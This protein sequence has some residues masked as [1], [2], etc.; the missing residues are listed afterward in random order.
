MSACLEMVDLNDPLAISREELDCFTRIQSDFK[1]SNP[2]K[3]TYGN[4]CIQ[5]F[6]TDMNKNPR[7]FFKT[8]IDLATEKIDAVISKFDQKDSTKKTGTDSWQINTRFITID[9]CLHS[10][11][12]YDQSDFVFEDTAIHR[13][14][15]SVIV[16]FDT[17]YTYSL[18]KYNV[19]VFKTVN[20]FYVDLKSALTAK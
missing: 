16:H 3:I 13:V 6:N 18:D 15:V 11:S 2:I 10:Y 5:K 9:L 19:D 4:I 7:P 14:V 1:K 12:E 8:T 20:E 17:K